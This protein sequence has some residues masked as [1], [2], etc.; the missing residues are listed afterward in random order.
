MPESPYVTSCEK[1]SFNG[2]YAG[3]DPDLNIRAALTREFG[4]WVL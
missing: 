2:A 4:R 3:S 1:L